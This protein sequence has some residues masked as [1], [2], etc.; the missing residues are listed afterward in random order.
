MALT[1]YPS[2]SPCDVQTARKEPF[3]SIW[4][5]CPKPK[6]IGTDFSSD[7]SPPLRPGLLPLN[8]SGF[9]NFPSHINLDGLKDSWLILIQ[10]N[11]KCPYS[12]HDRKILELNRGKGREEKSRSWKLAA[13]VTRPGTDPWLI[14]LKI[15]NL[16]KKI[17]M[18]II[19]KQ[20]ISKNAG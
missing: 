3:A 5:F 20:Q 4:Y 2:L 8:Q 16:A 10:D 6:G 13:R 19:A 17:I 12:S 7:L 11:N 14:P 9:R 15:N 18:R 1:P